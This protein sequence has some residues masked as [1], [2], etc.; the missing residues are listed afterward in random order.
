MEQTGIK[1]NTNWHFVDLN[2]LVVGSNSPYRYHQVTIQIMEHSSNW[3]HGLSIKSLQLVQVNQKIQNTS[4]FT[5]NQETQVITNP[6]PMGFLPPWSRW[7]RSS[8]LLG[9]S[10]DPDT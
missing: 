4:D 3:K 2:P 1:N 10:R 6:D 7:F 5:Q 8:S 9:T